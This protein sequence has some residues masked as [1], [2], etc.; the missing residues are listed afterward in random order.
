MLRTTYPHP[1]ACLTWRGA[2]ISSLVAEQT[3][4]ASLHAVVSGIVQGVFYRRFVLQDATGLGL[5]GRVRNLSDGRVEVEAEGDRR[6]LEQL[7]KWLREGPPGA[8][9]TDVVTEWS[10]HRG[11]HKD[12]RVDYN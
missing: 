6:K 9:V 5:R 1:G 3:D 11:E 12:F 2:A 8:Q 4:R 10:E 7:I